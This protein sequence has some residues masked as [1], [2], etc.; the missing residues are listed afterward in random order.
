MDQTT[1]QLPSFE[2]IERVYSGKPGC[3][4]GCN[5]NYWPENSNDTP[6]SKDTKAFKRIYN[7]LQQNIQQVTN[8]EY[9]YELIISPT[10]KYVIYFTK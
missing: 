7:I 6:T 4:C 5:G 1:T 8:N 10:R 2:K 9:W 3:M